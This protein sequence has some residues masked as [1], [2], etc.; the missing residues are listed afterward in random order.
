MINEK[1]SKIARTRLAKDAA[2]EIRTRDPAV[3]DARYAIPNVNMGV[4][5]HCGDTLVE[6]LKSERRVATKAY[7]PA[8]IE[9]TLLML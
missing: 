3:N 8:K 1:P 9:R 6:R 4:K 7:W 5:Y 2:C